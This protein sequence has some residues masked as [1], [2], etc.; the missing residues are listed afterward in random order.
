MLGR[1]VP[2]TRDA[3]SLR[4]I[5]GKPDEDKTQRSEDLLRAAESLALELGGVRFVTLAPVTERAGLHRTGVRRYYASRYPPGAT[6]PST[7]PPG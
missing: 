1:T 7:S 5:P 2:T 6:S 4:A 3:P